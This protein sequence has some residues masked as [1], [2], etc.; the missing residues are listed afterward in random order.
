[1]KKQPEAL[2][3]AQEL[4]T[5]VRQSFEDDFLIFVARWFVE[6][7][8]AELHRLHHNNEVLLNALWKA[9]GDNETAVNNTIESQ[10]ELK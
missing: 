3:L 5:A 2:R 6:D 10:G 8:A 4:T 7:A 1:M 9:C